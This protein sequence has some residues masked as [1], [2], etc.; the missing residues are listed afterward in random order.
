MGKP[1]FKN[2]NIEFNSRGDKIVVRLMDSGWNIFYEKEVGVG[3]KKGLGQL[4][5]DLDNY[6]VRLPT[7]KQMVEDDWFI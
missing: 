1:L 6:G 7:T 3:D 4:I 5:H 2:K